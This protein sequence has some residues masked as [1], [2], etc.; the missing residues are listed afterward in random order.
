MAPSAVTAEQLLPLGSLCLSSGSSSRVDWE[1]LALFTLGFGTSQEL[2]LDKEARSLRRECGLS[3]RSQPGERTCISPSKHKHTHFC[4]ENVYVLLRVTVKTTRLFKQRNFLHPKRPRRSAT[5]ASRK[6]TN[7]H[8]LVPELCP[9]P[10]PCT[11]R[12]PRMGGELAWHRWTSVQGDV[13]GVQYWG[14]F[15]M[16]FCHQ[17]LSQVWAV[18][19]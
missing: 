18:F 7:I 13:L 3:P 15:L 6:N 4:P 11:L 14:V 19:T 5:N 2:L 17:S 9:F 1:N 8:L 12:Q 10:C 16:R